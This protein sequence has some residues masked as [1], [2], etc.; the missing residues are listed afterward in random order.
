M[1]CRLPRQQ[2]NEP[3]RFLHRLAGLQR[4]RLVA[5]A[6]GDAEPALDAARP[7]VA[8]FRREADIAVV[9]EADGGEEHAALSDVPDLDGLVLARRD[10]PRTARKERD[11]LDIL[12]MAGKTGQQPAA[13]GIPQIDRLV[14]TA[15][16]RDDALAVR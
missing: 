9:A 8:A 5:A 12:L 15:A 2:R 4:H 10:Q 7:G 13:V 16:A 3:R 14:A 6:A 1:D 11:R